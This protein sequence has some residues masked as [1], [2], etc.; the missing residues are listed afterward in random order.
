M[1]NPLFV[2]VFLI[3]LISAFL[4][5]MIVYTKVSR[6]RNP[7]SEMPRTPRL[8]TLITAVFDRIFIFSIFVFA[9]FFIRDENFLVPL[10]YQLNSILQLVGMALL[11]LWIILAWWGILSLGEFSAAR[12]SR[13]K[14]GHQI[15][16]TGLYRYVRHPLYASRTLAY[17]GL[18]LLSQNFFFL[19]LIVILLPLLYMQAKLEENLLIE[20]FGEEYK[21]YRKT[22]GMLFPLLFKR[23]NKDS[24]AVD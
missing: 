20:V 15:V 22:T 13:L 6:R 19:I 2:K 16:K 12:W 24:T 4:I 14:D 7:S 8:L 17:L 18:F 21:I 11:T 5:L 23:R 10:S 1:L 3:L 9:F